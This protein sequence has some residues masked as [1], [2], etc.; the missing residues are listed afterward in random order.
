MDEYE[1][2]GRGVGPADKA[3]SLFSIANL[4]ESGVVGDFD[5]FSTDLG[6]AVFIDFEIKALS[7]E[8]TAARPG[9]GLTLSRE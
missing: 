6:G 9:R 7:C 1:Q 4:G 2:S 8:V 3:S 5:V